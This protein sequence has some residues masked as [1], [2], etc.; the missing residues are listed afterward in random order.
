MASEASK[1][2]MQDVN[3]EEMKE[4]VDLQ[5]AQK[6]Q[7]DELFAETGLTGGD[8]VDELAAELDKL[9]IADAQEEEHIAREQI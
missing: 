4:Q 1:Q 3:L 8:D 9:V 5:R 2:Q 7:W 6:E